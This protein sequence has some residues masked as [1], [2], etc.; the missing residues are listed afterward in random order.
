MTCI[1]RSPAAFAGLRPLRFPGREIR[2]QIDDIGVGEVGEHRHHQCRHGAL[3]GTELHV[4][5]RPRQVTWR[6]SGEVRERT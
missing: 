3:E 6:A 2:H 1:S 5:H 4:L